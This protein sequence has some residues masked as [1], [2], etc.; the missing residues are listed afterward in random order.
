MSVGLKRE[1]MLGRGRE[2]RK[3]EKRQVNG[4]KQSAGSWVRVLRA[5]GYSRSPTPGYDD[6]GGGDLRKIG[7]LSMNR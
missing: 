6:E 5:F 4:L 3:E 7:K 2:K 1:R